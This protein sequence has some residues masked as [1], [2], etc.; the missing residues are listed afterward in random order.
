MQVVA[1]QNLGSVDRLLLRPSPD[2]TKYLKSLGN[3]AISPLAR[4]LAAEENRSCTETWGVVQ[5]GRWLV[6]LLSACCL[7]GESNKIPLGTGA[8]SWW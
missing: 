3:V 4:Y 1:S 6:V 8:A 2:A 5:I 7:L